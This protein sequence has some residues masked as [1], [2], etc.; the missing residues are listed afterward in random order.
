M[1]K[2][3]QSY[4]QADLELV[5]RHLADI[6]TVTPK[7]ASALARQFPSEITP[8]ANIFANAKDRLHQNWAD[9]LLVKVPQSA[10]DGPSDAPSRIAY[11]KAASMRFLLRDEPTAQELKH[12][13]NRRALLDDFLK[14]MDGPR[15]LA[16]RP[17]L[18]WI[19]ICESSLAITVS[20]LASDTA[21]GL[22]MSLIETLLDKQIQ[23]YEL[24]FREKH[25]IPS[26]VGTPISLQL[27]A[28]EGAKQHIAAK[29]QEF[30]LTE[31]EELESVKDILMARVS[32]N[33]SVNRVLL[34][35][36]AI[37][38]RGREASEMC[39][40][41]LQRLNFHGMLSVPPVLLQDL[42]D[43]GDNKIRDIFRQMFTAG[44]FFAQVD[45]YFKRHMTE[46]DIEM[47]VSWSTQLQELYISTRG[48]HGGHEQHG[49]P[50]HK[51]I[52]ALTIAA[53]FY[54]TSQTAHEFTGHSRP[55]YAVFPDRAAAAKGYRNKPSTHAAEILMQ[56]YGQIYYSNNEWGLIANNVAEYAEVRSAKRAHIQQLFHF[57][58]KNRNSRQLFALFQNL[59]KMRPLAQP[60]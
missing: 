42:D 39:I 33:I 24:N 2:Q 25:R 16:Y 21:F 5:K 43:G 12:L 38:A 56:A 50:P 23:I 36:A 41:F 57:V 6:L 58:V 18:E 15:R 8:L 55:C 26:T 60:K 19:N 13:D 48:I 47:I 54:E 46:S 59:E 34:E 14:H 40:P 20:V 7:E 32:A 53:A 27:A 10:W 35:I 29:L 11:T 22:S 49:S 1:V 45:N 44:G 52:F 51:F 9:A 4:T 37:D 30:C 17:M 28:S 31:S 3:S